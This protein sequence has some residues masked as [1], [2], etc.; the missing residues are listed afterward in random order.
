MHHIYRSIWQRDMT[1]RYKQ[2][3]MAL[4]TERYNSDRAARVNLVHAVHQQHL[5]REKQLGRWSY[6]CTAS[7]GRNLPARE[8]LRRAIR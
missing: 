1:E 4:H 6:V 7:A 3:L 5:A 2:S 8:Q